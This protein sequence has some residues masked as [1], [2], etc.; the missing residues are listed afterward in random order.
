MHLSRTLQRWLLVVAGVVL[1]TLT[2]TGLAQAQKVKIAVGH[3]PHM[4]GA[5]AT[6]QVGINEGFLDAVWLVN[7]TNMIP[8]VEL[9]AVWADGGTEVPKAMDAYKK[10]ASGEPKPVAIVGE[11]TAVGLALKKWH[12]RD[13]IPD[14]EG[15]SDDEFY[16]LPSWTFST[17]CPYVNQMGAWV[18]YYLKEI[19]PKKGLN[20]PP[21]FAF[22]TW[23]NAFGRAS[24]TDNTRAYLKKKGVD[25]VGEEFIPNVP[26]DTTPQLLRLKNAGV[27][28]TYGGMYHTAFNVVLKDAEKLGMIDSI[29]FGL[30]GAVES[31]Q[32]I[33]GVGD[34]ARNTYV[35]QVFKHPSTWAKDA[36]DALRAFETNKREKAHA[37]IWSNGF[38]RGMIAANAVKAAV[39]KV[40]AKNVDGPAIYDA[41][42]RLN[43]VDP[44]VSAKVSFNAKKRYGVDEIYM[45]RLNNKTINNLGVV[46][47]P[48]L[49]KYAWE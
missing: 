45:W 46:V 41:L 33:N 47:P 20:R 39:E 30:T 37:S 25:L 26:T 38:Q 9:V 27:D 28:F 40:G 32:I 21:R 3:I 36:P 24:L 34:L 5:Y 31:D 16:N 19:W 23:D 18:D 6:G 14:V 22:L 17:V 1:L 29:S 48:N 13:A 12:T 11:S 8:G 2:L 35:T 10:L 49:T 44:Q 15:G 7:Q 42:T 4:T 43:K